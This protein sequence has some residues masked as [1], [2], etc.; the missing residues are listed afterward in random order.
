MKLIDNL[1]RL[2]TLFNVV[3]LKSYFTQ[4]NEPSQHQYSWTR[5]VCSAGLLFS[6]SPPSSW[7][8]CS[9]VDAFGVIRKCQRRRD[10]AGVSTATA[11]TDV[12]SNHIHQAFF[13]EVWNPSAQHHT[14]V[15][16]SW[17]ISFKVFLRWSQKRW[18]DVVLKHNSEIFTFFRIYECW[19]VFGV[20]MLRLNRKN[21]PVHLFSSLRKSHKK[22]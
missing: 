3:V 6:C 12:D 21:K 16:W 7:L 15:V 18:T 11:N 17:C 20:F 22:K 19:S 9:F 10:W 4:K 5:I 8:L 14:F 1:Y 2:L 13:F